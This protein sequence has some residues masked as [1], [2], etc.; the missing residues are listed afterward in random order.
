MVMTTPTL[1]VLQ[2]GWDYPTITQQLLG[3]TPDQKLVIGDGDVR[4]TLC[5]L[6]VG[7]VVNLDFQ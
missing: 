6:S 7:T 4:L 1:I 3:Y 5:P 2:N